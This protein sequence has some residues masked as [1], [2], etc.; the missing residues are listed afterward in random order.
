MPELLQYLQGNPGKTVVIAAKIWSHYVRVR[1]LK[2]L[3]NVRCNVRNI[4]TLN[5]F[6]FIFKLRYVDTGF[7]SSTQFCFIFFIT[8]QILYIHDVYWLASIRHE[9]EV[10][11]SRVKIA[12]SGNWLHVFGNFTFTFYCL[13]PAWCFTTVWLC[14]FIFYLDF[15]SV[16]VCVLSCV[17]SNLHYCH[18]KSWSLSSDS[19]SG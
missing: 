13:Y 14:S 10:S 8:L 19:V 18:R 12:I 16:F 9:D 11:F 4:K 15:H 5:F 1:Q 6:K 3:I 7:L 17:W 2:H